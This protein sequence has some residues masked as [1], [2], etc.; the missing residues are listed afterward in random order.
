MASTVATCQEIWLQKI[1]SQISDI[2][3]GQVILYIDNRSAIDLAKNSIFH[4]RS[5]HIDIRHHFIREYVEQGKIVI[6]HVSTNEQQADV[7][8]KV[9]STV[10]FEKMRKLLG[11]KDLQTRL[12]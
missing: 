6:K 4:G 8:T 7:L 3:A 10:K 2:K 1:L 9:L 11:V 12:D 5:K